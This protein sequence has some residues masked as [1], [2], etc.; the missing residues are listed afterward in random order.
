MEYKTITAK[1]LNDT[2]LVT[3]KPSKINGIG[4]FALQNIR[5]G[6][7]LCP[8]MEK[9]Y[10][11]DKEEIPLIKKDILNIILDRGNITGEYSGPYIIHPNNDASY[12]SFMN[13]S[14]NPNSDGYCATKNIKRGQEITEEYWSMHPLT[15]EHM[16]K[17]NII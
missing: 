1:E 6:Q 7:R 11:I 5:K 15:R 2:C 10:I 3:L 13:H 8:V 17:Q 16:T 12:I 9:T 14:K 4:V